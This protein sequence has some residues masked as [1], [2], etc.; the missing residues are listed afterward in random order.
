MQKRK[1]Q[2]G[3]FARRRYQR[4]L[5]AVWSR[6]ASWREIARAA[7]VSF[8]GS[9]A[10]SVDAL[11]EAGWL[12]RPGGRVTCRTLRPGPLFGGVLVN[13]RTGERQPL[14]LIA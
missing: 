8:G 5:L 6:R 12:K 14:R 10:Y 2:V 1:R 3:L 11:V 9:L 7:R 13:R 4:I